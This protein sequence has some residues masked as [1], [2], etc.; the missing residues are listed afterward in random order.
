[1]ELRKRLKT[2]LLGR[3]AHGQFPGASQLSSKISST[4]VSLV[5]IQSAR[6][7]SQWHTLGK[8]SSSYGYW[9]LPMCIGNHFK[10]RRS[11]KD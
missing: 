10:K 3:P 9:N 11:F 2:Q 1:M 8:V 5:K 7:D 4:C 6:E